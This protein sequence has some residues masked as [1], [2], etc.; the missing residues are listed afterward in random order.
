MISTVLEARERDIDHFL[1]RR[2]L[3]SPRRRHVG[4]FV[5][6][7]HIGPAVTTPGQGLDVRPHPHI[8]LAT[9]TYLFEGEIVHRDSLGSEQTIRPGAVNWMT[10]GRGIA[11][12]E[13]SGSE[14]RKHE[15][16]LHGF[17]V[18][19]G[20]PTSHE[21]DEPRFEHYPAEGIP[22]ID[23]PDGTRV[24]IV[25]G[26][27]FGKRSPVKVTSPLFYVVAELAAGATLAVPDAPERAVY[28]AE[29][30]LEVDGRACTAG[31]MVVFEATVPAS[32]R[33]V[34]NA[35]IALIGGEPLDG[36]RH[37]WWNFVSSSEARIEQAKRDWKEG[38]FGRIPGDDVEFIPLPEK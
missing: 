18:W 4:P 10:A 7:D 17:Q 30:E 26:E 2:V 21:E 15:Q 31:E 8:N 22:Q 19:V 25:A 12:S 37:L 3:P 13:R 20:L 24:R 23:H 16:H 29:G 11:H 14:A 38:H 28:I 34:N 32:V 27:A 33:A 6:F 5:F 1:V 35:R 36:E 9:V